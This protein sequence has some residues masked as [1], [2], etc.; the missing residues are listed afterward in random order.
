MPSDLAQPKETTMAKKTRKTV[1]KTA[2]KAKA[3]VKQA[4]GR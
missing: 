2:K 1:R 3:S 4:K